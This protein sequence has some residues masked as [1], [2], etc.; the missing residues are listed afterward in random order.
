MAAGFMPG[1]FIGFCGES[2]LP[3]LIFCL[4]TRVLIGLLS[5][6]ALVSGG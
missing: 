1:G 3:Y 5:F 6:V 4:D 2:R